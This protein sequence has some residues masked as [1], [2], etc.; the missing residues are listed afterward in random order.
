MIENR[1]CNMS[2]GKEKRRVAYI[3]VTPEF[4]LKWLQFEGGR[5]IDVIIDEHTAT[6]KFLIEHPEMPESRFGDHI[7]DI[8]PEYDII[9]RSR[10]RHEKWVR[11][12]L[13]G[14]K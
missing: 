6:P 11:R 1:L 14:R 5:L 8:N 9:Y 10:A 2:R 4:I 12:P 7:S 3:P 13:N